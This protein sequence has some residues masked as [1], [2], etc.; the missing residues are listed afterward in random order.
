MT[1]GNTRHAVLILSLAARCAFGQAVPAF[2]PTGLVKLGDS[3]KYGSYSIIKIGDGIYQIADRGDPKAR[4]GGLI[5]ADMYL[6]RG[7]SKALLVDLGN[8]YVDGYAGD[9]IPPR[10]NAAEEL[11][12][13]VDGLRGALP[14]EVAITHAHP[15]HDGMTR[16]FAGRKTILWMPKGEDLEAPKKQHGID[17]SVYTVFDHA[18]KTFD[19]GGGRVLKPLLIRGHSNGCTS[20]LLAKDLMIFTGDSM[21]IGA[22]RSLR[23]AEALKVWAEDTQKL[24]DYFKNNL[25]PY[26]RHSLKVFTGHSVENPI[27]GFYSA[28]H[29]MLDLD[30][31][32][33]RFL[34]DQALCAAATLKGAWTVPDSGLRMMEVTNKQNG[35]RV[36]VMFYGIGAI[37]IPVQA[38]Y[39]AA[40][41]PM[42][43]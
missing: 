20:Y 1:R 25:S 11:R 3:V 8:N 43:K 6:V 14:Y 15:D 39:E 36:N 23:S 32:D 35:R 27:A 10:K 19:L 28:N 41:L 12:A 42:P 34:Q 22:G 21:G 16:A 29:P 40:G 31:L 17:P 2:K 9:E 4:A 38:V 18:N 26:E 37:E 7:A 13:V 30:W 24:V 5:G 33:W